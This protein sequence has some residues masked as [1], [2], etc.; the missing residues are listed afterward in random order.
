[1]AYPLSEIM[2]E[3]K[4]ADGDDL[5]TDLKPFWSFAKYRAAERGSRSFPALPDEIDVNVLVGDVITFNEGEFVVLVNSDSGCFGNGEIC[6]VEVDRV[7]LD[8]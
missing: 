4:L 8:R 7:D 5:P 2:K 1:M 3:N 6:L